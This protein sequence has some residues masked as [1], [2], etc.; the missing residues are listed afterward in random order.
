MNPHPA[1]L[2]EGSCAKT[3]HH[4]PEIIDMGGGDVDNIPINLEERKINGDIIDITITH[5]DYGGLGLRVLAPECVQVGVHMG[6]HVLAHVLTCVGTSTCAHARV[7]N[8]CC[9]R[10]TPINPII[11]STKLI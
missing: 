8:R 3:L 2:D 4:D 7:D 11:M 1:S 10:F 6:A 9:S 5:I